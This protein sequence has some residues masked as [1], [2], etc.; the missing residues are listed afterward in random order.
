M[1]KLKIAQIAPYWLDVPPKDYGAV[2]KLVSVITEE[3]VRRGHDVTLFA[4]ASSESKAKIISPVE[5]KLV[6][7]IEHYNDSN[8]NDINFYVNAYVYSHSDEFDVIHSHASYFPF[9]L[10]DMVKTPTVHTLHYQLPRPRELENEIYKKYRHLNFIS[11]SD[12][13]RSHFDLNYISTV[14]NGLDPNIYTFSEKGGDGLLWLGRA[15]K[16]KGELGAIEVAEKTGEK[17]QLAMSVRKDAEE[18]VDKEIKP[19]LN[20]MI[21][22]ATNV[23]L[24]DVV[25]YYRDAKAFVFPLEW[26]EPFGLVMIEAMACGTPVIAYDRGSV[27]EIVVD[28]ETGYIVDPKEGTDGFVKAIKKLNGMTEERYLAMRRKCRERVE[29]NFTIERMVDR[30][31]QVYEKALGISKK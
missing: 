29:E 9:F 5:S 8:Y 12:E 15:K 11:I 10:C 22:L 18:Y 23:K 30:Y 3:L 24:E 17:L 6:S 21:K 1:K 4:T 25:N 31:E 28:G 19:H 16:F 14:Y 13:F 26:K 7:L 27:S 2:E 20:E